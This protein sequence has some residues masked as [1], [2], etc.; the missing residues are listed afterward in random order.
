MQNLLQKSSSQTVVVAAKSSSTPKPLPTKTKVHANILDSKYSRLKFAQPTH[1]SPATQLSKIKLPLGTPQLHIPAHFHLL[2]FSL[3]GYSMIAYILFSV[4]PSAIE[5][6]LLPNSYVPLLILSFVS[7]LF[8]FSFLL[9]NSRRGFLIAVVFT[10]YL[11]L[12]LQQVLTVPVATGIAVP[13]LLYELGM[14]F[15][16]KRSQK[17]K[18]TP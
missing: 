10:I 16:E 6:V 13:F 1:P 8:F 7:D 12:R 11:F 9:G 18:S 2:V 4:Q 17:R 3:I 5:H 15:L 14:T